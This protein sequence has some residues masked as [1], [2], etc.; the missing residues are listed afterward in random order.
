MHR[1]KRDLMCSI[2]AA[3]VAAIS[4]PAAAAQVYDR[5]AES[6]SAAAGYAQAVDVIILTPNHSRSVYYE[7][8]S[9]LLSDATAL[10][11]T[12]VF[13]MGA[14]TLTI[15]VAN[16]SFIGDDAEL[17]FVTA[18]F[19]NATPVLDYSYSSGVLT[20]TVPVPDVSFGILITGVL[21]GVNGPEF[22][23]TMSMSFALQ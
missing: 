8:S 2:V 10:H 4:V 20:A 19:I 21:F 7:L 6:V 11:A 18:G 23:V 1:T 9:P 12:F 17:V 14:G 3:I 15:G 16:S 13:T 22:P 5:L